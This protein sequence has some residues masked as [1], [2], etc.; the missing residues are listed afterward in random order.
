MR[1]SIL[2]K[3]ALALSTVTVLPVLASAADSG[4]AYFTVLSNPVDGR[5]EELVKWYKS[6]HIHDL[7]QIPG[8]KA[9]QF[10]QLAD[11]QYRPNQKHPL[12]YLVIWEVDATDMAGTFKRIQENLANGK[13]ARSDAFDS[14]TSTN[15]TWSP[16]SRRV[17]AEEAKGKSVEEVYKL[18]TGKN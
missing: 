4:T 5:E 8:V 15:D 18:A 11:P 2:L 12:K 16:I 9:A 6:Q 10:Y 17:T 13:T 14:K 3:A 7:L 1:K